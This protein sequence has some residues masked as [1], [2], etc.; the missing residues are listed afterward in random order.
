VTAVTVAVLVA[1]AV[2]FVAGTRIPVYTLGAVF[3][4]V[5]ASLFL[6]IEVS[7][8]VSLCHVAF[9]ALGATTFCHL[10]TGAGLP[11]L[12]GVFGA[13]LVAIPVGAIVAIPAIRLSGLFLALATLGFGIL[14]EKLLYVRGIM[15]GSLGSRTGARPAVLGLDSGRGYYFLCLA[16][17]IGAV[18][19]V[20]VIR[21]SRLGRLLNGLADSP[22]ALVTHGCNTSVTRLLVFCI[23]AAM[24]GVAG[25][26]Y[27][28]VVGSVSRSGASTAALVSFNSLVWVV[29]L[30]FVGRNLAAAPVLAAFVLVVGP[31][32]NT[33]PDIAQ[34]LTIAFG[35]VAVL[36]ATFGGS[37]RQWADAALVTSRARAAR[38][39]VRER[40]RLM[41]EASG[42]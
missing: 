24:A 36:S 15:F 21:R 26:L 8:Q 25:A 4:T 20:L 9:V 17:A 1:V 41:P 30:A 7:N 29:V 35:I 31:S 19:L 10:T 11:W 6:L 16:V 39:P 12:L 34:Y 2:P 13:G 5:Y 28:G 27:V 22:V 3:I 18:V 42:G 23:S 14:V 38:S 32:Y 33:S 40:V 37:L